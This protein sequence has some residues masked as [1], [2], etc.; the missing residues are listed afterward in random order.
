MFVGLLGEENPRVK[1]I[2]VNIVFRDARYFESR[3]QRSRDCRA[4]VEIGTFPNF[5]PKS[6]M[7]NGIRG[8]AMDI[9]CAASWVP[10]PPRGYI[11]RFSGMPNSFAYSTE[12]NIHDPA[13]LTLLNAFIRRGSEL[14]SVPPVQ[15]FREVAYKGNISFCSS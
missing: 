15:A 3:V 12:V 9:Q 8:R 5:I 7:Q 6:Q 14:Q 1:V 4:G 10:A 13:R 11:Q 2:R